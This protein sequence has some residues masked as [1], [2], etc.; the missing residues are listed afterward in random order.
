MKQETSLLQF[1][2]EIKTKLNLRSIVF[3]LYSSQ[4]LQYTNYVNKVFWIKECYCLDRVIPSLSPELKPVSLKL[5]SLTMQSCDCITECGIRFILENYRNMK[6]LVYHQRR[7][8]FEIIIKWSSEMEHEDIKSKIVKL[9]MLEH[10][11]PYGVTP[12]R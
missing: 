9:E 12:F 10:G 6:T 3:Y 5:E 1:L 11:F 8:V 2:R 4:I 7:S